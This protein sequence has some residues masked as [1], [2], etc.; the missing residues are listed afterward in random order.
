LSGGVIAVRSERLLSRPLLSS[1]CGG[2]SGVAVAF[3]S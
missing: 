1:I 3:V 2:W